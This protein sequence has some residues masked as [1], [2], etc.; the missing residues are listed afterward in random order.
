MCVLLCLFMCKVITVLT[1]L[2]VNM[3]PSNKAPSLV[4][5]I[6]DYN[7]LRHTFIIGKSFGPPG[8]EG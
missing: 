8:G 6:L 2:L 3:W 5:V 1:V 7:S 4:A